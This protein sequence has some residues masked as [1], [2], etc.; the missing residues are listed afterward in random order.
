MRK[1]AVIAHAGK[2]LGG[3]LGVLRAELDRRGVGDPIW[4][5]VPKSRKAPKRVRRALREGAE[6]IFVWG[7][8]GMVQRCIDVVAGTDAAIAIVPAGT[9]NLLATN[10]GIPKDIAAAVEIGLAGAR[11]HLDVGRV[12]G[13]G[14]AVMAGT[15]MDARMIGAADGALKDRL[16]R[17]AY[18]WTGA[19]NLRTD[20]FDARIDVDGARWFRGR[21]SCILLGNVGR[22]FGAM[23]A[24]PDARPDDGVLD[25]GVVTAEGVTQWLRMVVR[26]TVGDATK[27]P[28]AQAT[29][30]RSARIKLDR[31]IPYEL[32]GGARKKVRTLEVEVDPAAVEICVPVNGS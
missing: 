5:E 14:F 25:V 4:Y 31:K 19:R 21:A 6:L 30:A 18:V 11:R 29:H 13:E 10:L 15:G 2:S 22:V 16:G 17:L 24:F 20:A 3:G 27:S 23:D 9:A 12:N 32:D 26:A 8:D 7:G 28:F 1:V